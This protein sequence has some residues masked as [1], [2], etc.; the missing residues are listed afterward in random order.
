VYGARMT[1]GTE[2]LRPLLH[3]LNNSLTVIRAQAELLGL[4]VTDEGHLRRIGEITAAA[5]A[6]TDAVRRMQAI[7]RG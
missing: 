3:D 1:A 7:V 2:E 4:R 5:T 6:A